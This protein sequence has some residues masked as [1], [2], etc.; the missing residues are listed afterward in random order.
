MSN[1]IS[2]YLSVGVYLKGNSLLGDDQYLYILNLTL[3]IRAWCLFKLGQKMT[4]K[5]VESKQKCVAH[6]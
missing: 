1:M 3:I 5:S 2:L 6:N 4:P